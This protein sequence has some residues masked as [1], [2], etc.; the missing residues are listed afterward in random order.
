MTAWK[1]A[2]LYNNFLYSKLILHDSYI[3]S[4]TSFILRLTLALIPFG[5]SFVNFIPLYNTGTGNL[6]LGIDV[7]HNL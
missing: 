1:N 4:S 5:G 2:K 7:N 6:V 3:F